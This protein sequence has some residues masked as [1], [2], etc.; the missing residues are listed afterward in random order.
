[1][2]PTGERVPLHRRERTGLCR[3]SAPVEGAERVDAEGVQDVR[4]DQLLVLLLVV[5]AQCEQR[6]ELGAYRPREEAGDCL[7]DA[8]AVALDLVE[9]G[10]GHQ[11][12]RAARHALADGVIIGVEQGAIARVEL[13][14]SGQMRDEEERL[15]EPCR[16]R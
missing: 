14:V 8:Q 2:K 16:V 15:E 7:V 12:A 11:P 6:G 3:V 9:T 5:Q 13:R 4:E 10:P 1:M